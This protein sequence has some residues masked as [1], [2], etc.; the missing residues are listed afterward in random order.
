MPVFERIDYEAVDGIRVGRTNRALN[1][2]CIVYRLGNTVIDT[3]PPNQWPYVKTFLNE[4][5]VSSIL[6]THHHEDHSGNGGRAGE[7]TRAPV[8]VPPSGL[9]K[10]Q[11]GFRVSFMQKRTWGQPEAFE[12]QAVPDDIPLHDG[13]LLKTLHT[14]GHS[15]DMSCY[16]EPNRG[17]LFCGDVYIARNTKYLRF[18]ENVH[19]QIASLAHLL[20]QDFDT[21]FCAHRGVLDGAKDHL[22]SKWHHLTNI[23]DEARALRAQGKT[24][25][26][27]R[28]KMLGKEN[29]MS[30]V[31]RG[32]FSKQ[33]FIDS[34]LSKEHEAVAN[35]E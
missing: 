21:L 16:W 32:I 13:I 4:K 5:Q 8:L 22:R 12:A 34:C 14:P 28:L 18:D 29:L 10:I 15:H 33:N 2:T 24:S 31:T 20:E 6:I 17:W 35:K 27:V 30:F 25:K 23:R 3:G 26:E 1:S 7:L 11:K 19:Q 9:A